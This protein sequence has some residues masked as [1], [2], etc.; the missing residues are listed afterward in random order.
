MPSTPPSTDAED[1]P[2]V[3]EVVAPAPS[4]EPGGPEAFYALLA[5]SLA[6]LLFSGLRSWLATPRGGGGGGGG[7]DSSPRA[8]LLR[9]SAFLALRNMAP[10][11]AY[12][13]SSFLYELFQTSGARLQAIGLLSTLGLYGGSRFFQ[14]YFAKNISRER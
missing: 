8:S 7:G 12:S 13:Y 5:R 1:V 3:M 2:E 4:A 9:G 14:G 6:G 10:T 11:A